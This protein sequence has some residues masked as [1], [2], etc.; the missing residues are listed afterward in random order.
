MSSVAEPQQAQQ[1]AAA[2]PKKPPPTLFTIVGSL[3]AVLMTL[4][5]GLDWE[6]GIGFSLVEIYENFTRPNPAFDGLKSIDWTR[7][8]SGTAQAA[9]LETALM[10]VISTIT[11]CMVG[12]PMAILGS[13]LGA[14]NRA[15]F[16]ALRTI[17]AVIRAIPDLL[18]ALIFVAAVGTGTLPGMIALFLF[19][20][21]VVAKL[22]A[23]IIDGIDPGPIESADASGASHSQMVRVALLPQILPGYVSFSLYA[24]ELNLR[25]SAVLGLVGAGGIGELLRAYYGRGQYDRVWGLV[26]GFFIVVFVIERFSMALRKRLV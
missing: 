20:I 8:S 16:L 1:G 10:A 21:G 14:P 24:F 25:A 11:G 13:P 7:L 12:L 18:W 19:S 4:V 26:V 6:H 22:T 9:F 23:D 2:R 15:V 3:A 5:T 17:N